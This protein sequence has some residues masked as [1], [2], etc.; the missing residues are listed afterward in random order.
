MVAKVVLACVLMAE[1]AINEA[2]QLTP[3]HYLT[4][5]EEFT[6]EDTPIRCVSPFHYSE[7]AAAAVAVW[8]VRWSGLPKQNPIAH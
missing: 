1:R 6:S 2:I 7:R 8:L 5:D 4:S 3:Y